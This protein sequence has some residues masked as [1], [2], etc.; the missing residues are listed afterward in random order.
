MPQPPQDTNPSGKEGNEAGQGN[1]EAS[2]R[3]G[4]GARGCLGEERSGAKAL[5][6]K[7]G[8]R[9]EAVWPE[10]SERRERRE[11]PGRTGAAPMAQCWPGEG[12]GSKF[13]K[14]LLNSSAA[15]FK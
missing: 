11:G 15:F 10:Q 9:G 14:Q 13:L 4:E 5:R 1:G 8:N 2:P 12:L 3:E 7:L 6:Q